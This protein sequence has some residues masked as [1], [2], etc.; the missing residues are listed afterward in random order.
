VLGVVSSAIFC[1]VWADGLDVDR[2]AVV[3]RAAAAAGLEPD[4]LLSSAMERG[5]AEMLDQARQAFD[6]DAGPGVPT[7]VVDDA[8]FQGKD[9]VDWPADHV[10]P[11]AAS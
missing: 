10:R 8:G 2:P 4:R 6:R 11:G 5:P 7:R 1:A 3:G 9:R